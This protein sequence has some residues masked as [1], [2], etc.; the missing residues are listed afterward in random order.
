MTATSSSLNPVR[1][2]LQQGLALQQ[3]GQLPQ[4]E[5]RYRHALQL[6]PDNFDALHLLG[7]V[8]Y[9][10]GRHGEAVELIDRAL[11]QNSAD[12]RA[13]SNRGLALRELGRH[14]DA[15]SS[16]DCALT[17][18]PAHAGA[19]NN[20]G[21][22][23]QSAGRNAEAL[24]SYERAL[25]LNPAFAEAWNNRGIS[26]KALDQ[27]QAAL[28]SYE[29]A[30]ALKPEFAEAWNNRGVVLRDLRHDEEA[31]ACFERA[32]ALAPGYA[33]GWNN[34]G[35]ALFAL[36]RLDDALASYDRATALKPGYAE[37]WSNRGMALQG[38]RRI[39]EAL[40]S[41]EHSIHLEPGYADGHNNRGLV[42]RE[43]KQ[44]A[45][46]LASCERAIHIKP[47]RPEA[48]NS[49]GVVLQDCRRIEEAIESYAQAI[50]AD[51]GYAD[52]H[53]NLALCRLL[54]GD[55]AQGW[56]G[57]EWRWRQT[58]PTAQKHRFAQAAW[59]G[60]EPLEGKT[61]LLHSE[62]GYGDTLQFC[63]YAKLAHE[64]GARVILEVPGALRPLLECLEGYVQVIES[65]AALPAFD[66]HCPLLSMPLAFKTR[67]DTIPA[68]VPYLRAHALRIAAWREQLR[69]SGHPRVGLVWSG[70]PQ[71]SND[72]NRSIP[73]AEL[74][75]LLPHG[76][77]YFSLQKDLRE[78]DTAILATRPDILHLGDGINDFADSA[79]LC[80]LMDLVVSVDTSVAHLAGALGRPLW[81][82]L[83]Y[84]PDW[85]WLLDRDDSPWY[86]SARL[87]RQSSPGD[88]E[89]ALRQICDALRRRYAAGAGHPAQGRRT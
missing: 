28:E 14:D 47:D 2:L 64:R 85:R 75:T 60:D 66:L 38:L 81:V 25:Q 1:A 46:A 21:H 37:A 45:A 80:E 77:H 59:C 67:L 41:V 36:H 63:R 3:S 56:P 6:Q 78:D 35:T 30:L 8:A 26:Q 15:L 79:A 65:G 58:G 42:L 49:R 82:M 43:T 70:N 18:D 44:L 55:F 24:H 22:A 16:F 74:A 50:A 11:A 31:L 51:A 69:D 34:R 83:P 27:P 62:Q 9:Q 61:L 17:I 48:Y 29:R 84:T 4:A 71:H 40:A 72:R 32:V 19:W 20:R 53:W 57:Y 89:I 88:W 76:P 52:A 68:R 13:H 23:L 54:T 33:D 73:L 86:P 39:D 7:V 12:A 87:F 10:A 5:H